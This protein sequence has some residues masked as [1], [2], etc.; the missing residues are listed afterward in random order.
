[1]STAHK[2]EAQRGLIPNRSAKKV[3]THYSV[4]LP[5]RGNV[6]IRWFRTGS[7]YT[8]NG[9]VEFLRE[10]FSRLPKRVWKV[11]VRADSGFFNGEILVLKE[12]N[13]SEYS[14]QS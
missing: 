2:K 14:L 5:K 11:F 13:S 6:V 8:G 9:A 4:L 10:C 12:E 3:I 1:M 7:A